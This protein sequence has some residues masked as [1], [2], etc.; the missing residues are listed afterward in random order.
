M[1][2]A[3]AW[4]TELRMSIANTDMPNTDTPIEIVPYAHW[5]A[6]FASEAVQLQTMLGQW[7]VA[8]PEHIGSTAVPGL[9]AKPIIDIMAPVATLHG[10]LDA[11]E[12]AQRLG[13]CYFPYKT[14]QM[15][16]FCKPSP[17]HRTHHLHLV[18]HNSRLWSERIAFRD[19]L[20]ASAALA[21][22]YAALKNDL[23]VR[24]R[25]DREAYT[26]GKSAFVEAVLTEWRRDR[27]S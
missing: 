27:L 17:A 18:P 21:A 9:A 11:I 24:Y 25:C 15:H 20:R 16:W 6:Q 26:E 1:H 7:L 3:Y 4:Q 5:P 23:A 22:Q 10:S 12:A 13:Y 14:E 8:P 2:T 19:A